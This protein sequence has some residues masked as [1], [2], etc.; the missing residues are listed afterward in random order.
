MNALVFY[1][2]DPTHNARDVE[3]CFDSV[4]RYSP[5]THLYVIGYQPQTPGVI[6][7]PDVGLYQSAVVAE[8]AYAKTFTLFNTPLPLNFEW[9]CVKRWFVFLEFCRRLGIQS[10]WTFDADVLIFADL[11]AEAVR[12]GDYASLSVEQPEASPIVTLSI[13]CFYSLSPLECFCQWMPGFLE[14]PEGKKLFSYSDMNLWTVFLKLHPEFQ[15]NF[16]T[17]T[18]DGG[19]F[20]PNLACTEGWLSD[21]KSKALTWKGGFPYGIRAGSRERLKALHCWFHHASRMGEYYQKALA[22]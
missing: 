17:D 18:R 3:V 5:N 11:E 8:P 10:F 9:T 22:S 6:G 12:Y 15:F 1:K 21:G 14:S 2:Y 13:A 4:R 7:V 16:L 19:S 20:D